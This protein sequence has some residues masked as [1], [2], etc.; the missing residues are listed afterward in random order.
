ALLEIYGEGV[1]EI[2]LH[3]LGH[4][5]H[6]AFDLPPLPQV[7]QTPIVPQERRTPQ[8][9]PSERSDPLQSFIE[10][11]NAWSNGRAKMPQPLLGKF[12]PL[13][14]SAIVNHISWDR[15]MLVRERLASPTGQFQQRCV[16]F[17]DQAVEAR[18]S[19]TLL[20]LPLPGQSRSE[21]AIA[22]QALLRF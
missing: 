21:V 11:L 22:L 5:I 10:P 13:I 1:N 6:D 12:R 9:S 7:G 4:G 8:V 18:R 14:Y 16:V 3:N 2:G 15:E 17:E 20:S 19:S